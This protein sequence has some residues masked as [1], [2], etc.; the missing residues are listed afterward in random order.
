MTAM[1]GYPWSLAEEGLNK[2]WSTLS[3]VGVGSINLASHYHSV[4]SMQPRFPEQLFSSYPGGCYFNPTAEQFQRTTI[5]PLLNEVPP[6]DDPLEEI[7]ESAG[8][9]GIDVNGWVVLFHNSRLGSTNP[10]YRAESAYGDPQ[11]H[12][13]CPSYPDV[14]KYFAAVVQAVANRGVAEIHLEKAGFPTVFHGHGTDFGHDKRQILTSRTEELL[15]SQCFC[16]GCQAAAQLRGLDL[17]A[18]QQT[19]H[20][21]LQMSFVRPHLDAP[22]LD[23][24]IAERPVLQELFDYRASVIT[25]LLKQLS[26]AAG[27]TPLNY[28]VMDGGGLDGDKVWPSG[29][30]L[31][32]LT[33]HVNRVTAL[34]YVSDPNIARERID[35]INRLF[36]GPVDIGVTLAHETI[37]SAS[38]LQQLVDTVTAEA[39]GRIHVYNYSLV[40]DTQLEWHQSAL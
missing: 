28:Y 34:C 14:R 9:S 19:V 22:K 33:D 6:F 10:D 32:D 18:A 12:A 1:W 26:D 7:V 8:A 35:G 13:L 27:D 37:Q 17:D 30:R 11:D 25:D 5:D 21:L 38:K 24:L 31:G 23:A 39:D 36:D 20:D 40:T 2:A 4:R 3:D 15:L 29:I 16:E